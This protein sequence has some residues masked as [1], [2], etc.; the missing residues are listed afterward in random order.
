MD[1]LE[2]IGSNGDIEFFD[3]N[4]AKGL[5]NI[6]Q[7]PENDIVVSDVSVAPFQAMLDFRQKPYQLILLNDEGNVSVGGHPLSS[8]E[9][10]PLQNLDNIQLG[11]YTLILV[12]NQAASSSGGLPST[13]PIVVPSTGLQPPPV[14]RPPTGPMPTIAPPP[15]QSTTRPITAPL[16]IPTRSTTSPE[17]PTSRPETGL[18]SGPPPSGSVP[19][20]PAPATPVAAGPSSSQ[21][22]VGIFSTRPQD[23][24]DE[25]VLTE[26]SESEWILN[27]DQIATCQLTITNAGPLVAAFYVTIQG[28][29]E[30]WVRNLTPCY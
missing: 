7:H 16:P 22:A 2:I 10:R 24:L 14:Q 3:L 20:V 8:Q 26:L 6:G 28:L 1:Q 12:E 25:V 15:S 18:L 19:A 13:V 11:A 23:Q 21:R 5:I 9:H 27:V 17:P 4:P 29:D 30:S